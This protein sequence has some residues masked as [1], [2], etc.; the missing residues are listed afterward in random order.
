MKEIEPEKIAIIGSPRASI[1][2]NLA[3]LNLASKIDT[4]NVSSAYLNN[5]NYYQTLLD[6]NEFLATSNSIWNLEKSNCNVVVSSNITEAV[7]Y[8][9]LRAHET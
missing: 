2:D 5:L 1:E 3:L 6:R 9:H 7:S 4:K 8:T